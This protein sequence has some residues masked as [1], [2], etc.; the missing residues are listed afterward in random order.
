[1][2]MR[3]V[4]RVAFILVGVVL[5]VVVTEASL[6]SSSKSWPCEPIKSAS[7]PTYSE[8]VLEGGT[9]VKPTRTTFT[10]SGRLWLQLSIPVSYA[11]TWE[12]AAVLCSNRSGATRRGVASRAVRQAAGRAAAELGAKIAEQPGKIEQRTQKERRQR[13]KSGKLLEVVQRSW[14]QTEAVQPDNVQR[15][16]GAKSGKLLEVVC[17]YDIAAI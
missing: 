2:A 9:A 3:Q 17:C 8:C 11:Y 7:W 5:L 14:A 4:H 1:M 12:S 13:A 16:Q 15:K 6:S 10:W